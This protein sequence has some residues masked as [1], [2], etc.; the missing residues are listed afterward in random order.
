MKVTS[1]VQQINKKD[2]YSVFLDGK[3]SFSLSEGALLESKIYKNQVLSE[4][5]IKHFQN[6]SSDDK[7]YNQTLQLVASRLKTKWE[8]E[9]YLKQKGASP[10]LIETTLNKLSKIGLID[11][12]KYARS[13]ISTRSSLRPTSRRKMLADLNKKH[14]SQEAINEV[15][16]PDQDSEMTALLRIIET[17]KRQTK[18][19]DNTKLMQYLAR[20][21]FNYEDIK[22]ALSQ[23]NS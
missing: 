1:I 4:S 2:R 23:T 20:Q 17:K 21:G 16:G 12:A 15:L 6:L 5:E 10:T 11:D 19:Q 8:V 14:L 13:Y 3:Y 7:L 18:Y 22:L 9:V